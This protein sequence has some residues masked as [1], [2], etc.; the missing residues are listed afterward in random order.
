MTSMNTPEEFDE[1]DVTEDE[2]DAM[3]ATA[4][5]VAIF[6]AVLA[7]RPRTA[8]ADYYTL[9]VSDP[10]TVPSSDRWGNGLQGRPVMF[11]PVTSAS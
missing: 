11:A 6:A 7:R 10:S 3:M 5:P 2:F 9:T 1:I 4:E 8:F